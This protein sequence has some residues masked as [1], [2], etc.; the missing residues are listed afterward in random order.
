MG[1]IKSKGEKKEETTL[2]PREVK[3]GIKYGVI[4][5]VVLFIMSLAI[6]YFIGRNILTIQIKLCSKPF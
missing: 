6:I 5:F 3:E 2:K 4:V 1:K